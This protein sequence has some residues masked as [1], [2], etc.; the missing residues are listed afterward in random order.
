M[1]CPVEREVALA[2]MERCKRSPA[3][4]LLE[5]QHRRITK[6]CFRQKETRVLR[7]LSTP[8]RLLTPRDP[9][10]LSQI[11]RVLPFRLLYKIIADEDGPQRKPLMPTSNRRRERSANDLFAAAE[12]PAE[13]FRCE[14]VF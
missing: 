6:P 14:G 2:W 7:D 9:F 11:G 5:S 4:A 8:I 10:F 3:L 12:S 13:W 1:Y